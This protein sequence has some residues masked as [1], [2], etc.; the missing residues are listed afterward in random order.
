[1]QISKGNGVYSSSL[2]VPADDILP[3]VMFV[4]HLA[5][6]VK[7]IFIGQKRWVATANWMC[8]YRH[9]WSHR[10]WIL[11]ILSIKINVFQYKRCNKIILCN[12]RE[13]WV[14]GEI[15][16]DLCHRNCWQLGKILKTSLLETY[17]CSIFPLM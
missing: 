3:E 14:Y 6:D 8:L 5:L 15:R 2:S 11:D 7:T 12:W 16:D 4:S 10:S 13:N 17:W 1:M 9:C